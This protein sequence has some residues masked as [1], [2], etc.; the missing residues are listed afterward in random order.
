MYI[1]VV[2]DKTA[3]N[4]FFSRVQ[5]ALSRF[6]TRPLLPGAILSGAVNSGSHFFLVPFLPVPF[7]PVPF[8]PD[9][10]CTLYCLVVC[11]GKFYGRKLRGRL[12]Q[13][14]LAEVTFDRSTVAE[15]TCDRSGVNAHACSYSK[16]VRVWGEGGVGVG[17]HSLYLVDLSFDWLTLRHRVVYTST[18]CVPRTSSS[19]PKVRAKYWNSI[20][21]DW[22]VWALCACTLLS[23]YRATLSL[24]HV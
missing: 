13:H 1:F 4:A 17:C 5:T 22:R 21:K 14:C 10:A 12:L 24:R 3:G 19:Y 23:K 18:S 6:G 11:L 16:R 7:S 2:D 20:V 9:P 8:F 15:M